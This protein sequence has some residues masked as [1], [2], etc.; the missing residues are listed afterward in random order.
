MVAFI[1]GAEYVTFSPFKTT[2]TWGDIP[3]LFKITVQIMGVQMRVRTY[4]V[5]IIT[6]FG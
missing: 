2:P 4:Y 3:R 5:S 6:V 1:F